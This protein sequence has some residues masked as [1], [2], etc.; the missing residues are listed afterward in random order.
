VFELGT[1]YASSRLLR[2]D[3]SGRFQVTCDEAFS[4]VIRGCATANG[5]EGNTWLTPDLIRAYE[6]L[7]ELGIAHSIEVWREGELAGGTYGIGLGGL[8][9]AESMF[10]RVRDASKIALLHLHRHL[11]SRGYHLWDIQQLTS[12]TASLGAREIPRHE[13]LERLSQALQ[14]AVTFG[15]RLER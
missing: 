6:R 1:F 3:R 15:Y 14:L 2:T 4:N 13:Y 10:F 7:F 8:F 12:H 11:I 9:A 5:R